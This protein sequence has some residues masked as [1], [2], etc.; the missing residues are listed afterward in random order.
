MYF[1]NG[2]SDYTD[3]TPFG[4]INGATGC[5]YDGDSWE[6][7][8]EV[9]GDVARM[10][11]YMAVRYESGDMVDLELAEYSSSS[12]LHGKLSTLLQWH[13]DDP[14]D[15]WELD[16]NEKIYI[17]QKNRNPFIN[18][19]EYVEMIWG[20]DSGTGGT[21]EWV[22]LFKE[23]FASVTANEAI[24]ITGWTVINESGAKEW[25]GKDYNSNKY[26]QMSAYQG[27]ASEIDWLITEAIDLSE[28]SDVVL[29][30]DT[31]DGYNKGAVL[32][33]LVSD[34]FNGDQATANWVKLDAILADGASSSGY[35]NQF[36]NS[37]D[38][39]LSAFTG[40]IHIAFKYSGSTT[41]STTMQVDNVVVKGK[42]VTLKVREKAFNNINIYPN[43][44]TNQI[45]V[46]SDDVNKIK[47]IRIYN[48]L[49]QITKFIQQHEPNRPID[50]STLVNGI[51][52][53]QITNNEGQTTA[54][55]LLIK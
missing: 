17:E 51:Y 5:K 49:G 33:V 44:A 38:I 19:P 14:V 30:F 50:I 8:D 25:S 13:I 10:L 52:V 1:D 20:D 54:Q 11:F 7:R 26:A 28:S 9:K 31:K 23:G 27:D 37:G 53:V 34:N 24:S 39:S 21:D 36:T 22:N 12:G 47:E 55:K 29:N 15:K 43:P 46:S 18:H 42:D 48:Q 35:A 41:L 6:P 16:R 2:G 45:T 32:E 40:T 3:P 4:G